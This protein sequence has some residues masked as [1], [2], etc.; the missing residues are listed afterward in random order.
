MNARSDRVLVRHANEYIARCI[1]SESPPRVEELAAELQIPRKTITRAIGRV[2]GRSAARYFR[3]QQI[4]HQCELIRRGLPLT[5]VAYAA[6]FGTRRTF[7]RVFRAVLGLTP[8][9][10]RE[11]HRVTPHERARE[12]MKLRG[13]ATT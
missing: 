3:E 2:T 11:K 13:L 5:K 10:Y 6:G 1:A 12:N 9:A 7:Y 4:D 8:A